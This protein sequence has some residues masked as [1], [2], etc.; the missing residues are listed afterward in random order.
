MI[1]ITTIQIAALNGRRYALDHPFSDGWSA[2]VT[3]SRLF[4]GIAERQAFIEAW[5]REAGF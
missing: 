1:T 5:R 2:M 4:D 3:A